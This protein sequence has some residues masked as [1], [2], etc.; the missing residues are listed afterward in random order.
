MRNGW[1]PV[2]PTAANMPA[3]LPE[4][5]SRTP[6]AFCPLPKSI[7]N[8]HGILSKCLST[9]VKPEYMRRNPAQVVTLPRAERKEI[10]PLTDEQVRALLAATGNDGYETLLKAVVFTGLRL[11]EAIGLTWDCVDFEKRRLIVN[12]QLQKRPIADG[13]FTFTPLKNDKTRVIAPAPFVPDL[14]KRWQQTQ[15]EERLR[16]GR[17]WKG[18]KSEKERQTALV[19]PGHLVSISTRRRS[20]IT[21][22]NSPYRSAHRTRGCMTCAT[23]MRCWPCKTQ[24]T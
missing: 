21:S 17:E 6:A 9:A 11:A 2:T 15:A 22:R 4:A 16:A 24:T 20:T 7:R 19:L 8:V 10:K 5:G 14:L 1:G 13:G 12:K 3:A 23:P 18:W